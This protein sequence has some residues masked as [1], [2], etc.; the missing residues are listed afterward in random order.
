MRDYYEP[1]LL[2]RLMACKE[3]EKTIPNACANEFKA[4]RPLASLNRVQPI[5]EVLPAWED[6]R[7]GIARV[8]VKVSAHN[9][10]N[11]GNGKTKAEPY[12]V[13]LFRDGQLVGWAPKSSVEWQ[14]EPPPTGAQ[15]DEL[16]L[17]RWRE[18]TRVT[19]DAD[20]TKRLT[21]S[22]QVPRRAD[23]KQ[24]TFT[25][26]AFNE[27]RVKST[28]AS[29]SLEVASAPK[30]R[31]GNAYIVSVGVNRTESSPNWDLNYAANDARKM[32]DVLG[33]KLEGTR[34]FAKVVRV[35]LISDNAANQP[36][37]GEAAATKRHV[38]AVLDVLAGR[39]VVDEQLKKEV[40]NIDKL[41]LAQPEDLVILAFSSHGYTDKR[42]V[43]HMVLA[44]IGKNQP[45]GQITE[46]LQ[47]R[48][49]SSDELSV[50]LREVDAGEL[51]MIVDACQSEASINAEGFK[52]GP[53]G[54]RGLGQ[55]A[56]DKGMRVLAASKAKE[57]AVERGGNIRQG[58]LSYAL[59]QEGLSQQ[60]ADF[61]PKDGK[62]ILKEW[63]AYG[64]KR[65]PELFQ[66]GD[67][68]GSIQVRGKPQ[69]T[70]DGYW[71]R[72]STPTRYQQPVLF[73]FAKKGPEISLATK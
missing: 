13:R 11:V 46:E 48:A 37:Q 45:Q 42:G 64:E 43:F 19:L 8:V 62:I 68:R 55:L 70:R 57:S 65:V 66:E 34:Q 72:T 59:T 20:G 56:Y 41:E 5:V 69:G 24:V 51:V 7:A 3:A 22:V 21:F 4:V 9:D 39:R 60:L 61:Q 26:Y 27:D 67:S 31:I 53:M 47:K 50:W 1:A 49:L 17:Q 28:T 40:P 36:P 52:P 63:L 10:P 14:L 33:N 25:A 32:S 54:S 38:Q 44:D 6:E 71:G 15:A 12:D 16:E 58:L 2:Q 23:L 35:R 73:D 29:K 18:K 30:A